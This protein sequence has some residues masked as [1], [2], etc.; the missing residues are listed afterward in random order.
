MYILLTDTNIVIGMSTYKEA[1]LPDLQPGFRIVTEMQYNSL[2]NLI[3]KIVDITKKDKVQPKLDN[4]NNDSSDEEDTVELNPEYVL[5]ALADLQAQIL[6]LEGS[7]NH[8]ET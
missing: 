3:D 8:E 1:L 2:F 5:E 7:N 6:E 4:E